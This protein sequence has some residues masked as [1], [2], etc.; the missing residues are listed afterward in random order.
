MLLAWRGLPSWLAEG[1]TIYVNYQSI[2]DN[3]TTPCFKIGNLPAMVG[4]PAL[5]S[6]R[7]RDREDRV[8]GVSLNHHSVINTPSLLLFVIL[9]FV[10]VYL[11]CPRFAD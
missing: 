4:R 10:S 2:V 9:R 6:D 1:A 11:F 7:G 5:S 8:G 3:V